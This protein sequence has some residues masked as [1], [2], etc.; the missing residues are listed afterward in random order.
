MP[1]Q[2]RRPRNSQ[3]NTS[4][5]GYIVLVIGIIGLLFAINGIQTFFA[6]RDNMENS[7]DDM[8]NLFGAIF[9][10][11]ALGSESLLYGIIGGIIA[12][13]CIPVGITLLMRKN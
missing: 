4:I 3:N 1:A 6:L 8:A 12:V 9:L 7:N 13:I 5:W 11:A 2:K 10:F